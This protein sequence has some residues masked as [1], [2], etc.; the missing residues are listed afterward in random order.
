MK[1][2]ITLLIVLFILC[3]YNTTSY[4]QT[5]I[6]ED[7][8]TGSSGF[9]YQDDLFN[10]SSEP[11]YAVGIWSASGGSNGS[12][13]L[14]VTLGG[15]DANTISNMS[16]GWTQSFNLATSAEVLISFNFK[17]QQSPDY[18]QTEISEALLSID[19]QLIGNGT[20]TFIDQVKGDVNG[21]PIMGS[22]Q[23][24][25]F[26]K[27]VG[28]LSAGSHTLNIGGYNSLKTFSNELTFI[29][30]D[31]VNV[32]VLTNMCDNP[33]SDQ[34]QKVTDLLS[35]SNYKS[36]VQQIA[37]FGDR[38]QLTGA[39]SVS[40]DN[41]EA[42][43]IL[44]LSNMGYTV[45]FED[46]VFQN[47]SRRSIYVTKV[48]SVSPDQMYMVSAHFDGRGG[49]QACNDDGSGS[50][51]IMEI[52]QV[53][54]NPAV[55]S[56]ISVRMIL[57]NN[58]ETGLNGSSA[59]A[60]SRKRLRGIE[61]PRGSG[62]YPEPE[63]LGIIQ[64]DMMMFDHGLPAQASQIAGA[65]V[66]IEYQ[67]NSTFAIQSKALADLVKA[68]NVRF[69][70]DYPSEVS[71]DMNHT[72]SKSFQNLC[73]AI[74]L[75]E[76]R[77][78]A[79]IGNGSD[80]HW[81]QTTDVFST[82]SDADFRLGYNSLQTTL[83]FLSTAAGIKIAGQECNAP[84]DVDGDGIS[85]EDDNCP[86]TPNS[87]QSDQDGDLIGDV[88]DNCPLL[89]NSLIGTTCDDGNI[90]TSEDIYDTSCN[91]Q[92]VFVDTDGDG[93][94]I[95]VDPDDNDGC[96]P[97]NNSP[98]CNPCTVINSESFETGYGI[99]IDGGSDAFRSNS[100]PN[101]GSVSLNLQD[102]SSSSIITTIPLDFS[103][104]ASITVDFSYITVSMDN[105]NEDFWLQVSRDGGITY[106]DR[107][108]VES[109]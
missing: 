37:S 27:V 90:C 29:N 7:F 30:I 24:F 104:F 3:I 72:D 81:H 47:D 76:N 6:S 53:L 57:W 4:G 61:N 52:A 39:G 18:E 41:A 46:Y 21:G 1:D 20:K 42:W 84:V 107:G 43:A 45:K 50:A 19:N 48:G 15:V 85:N 77:R 10:N 94:C 89:N 66:D 5:L 103:H 59:Y 102:N 49:G 83:G 87:D 69:A 17:L 62:I 68:S 28:P 96:V 109:Q 40:Y 105:A 88:C 8:N 82:F 34:S 13:G 101:T 75:R 22:E 51:I 98:A 32:S 95:G 16:G 23:F 65:D 54:S 14:T 31:D 64:H 73:P 79:E 100:F 2:R 38:S 99:W 33:T 92:G 108:G 36:R 26:K 44:K 58:E 67:Q 93:F 97:D 60:N 71:N 86:N 70:T 9:T 78:V 106:Y 74:S 11:A 63:W 56:D 91:C 80:P 35:F 12:G 55:Q 25:T